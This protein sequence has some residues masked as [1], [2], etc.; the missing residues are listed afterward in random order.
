M[1]ATPNKKVDE[2]VIK[3]VVVK[4]FFT[5]SYRR[6]TPTSNTSS[7]CFSALNPLMTRIPPKVSVNL[8]L[9]SA[10]I[11]PRFRKMGRMI[12]KAFNAIMAKMVNGIKVNKVMNT[13]MS[14][15]KIRETTAVMMPPTSCT[16]PVP[17]RFR[18]PSTSDMIRETSAPDF[19]LSKNRTGRANTFFCTCA[20]S[21]EI[22]Y[23]AC[24]LKIL[25]NKKEVTAC[26]KMANITPATRYFSMSTSLFTIT[27]SMRCLDAIGATKLAAL[28]MAMSKRPRSTNLRLGQIMVLNAVRIL[29]FLLDIAAF[30]KRVQV[31]ANWEGCRILIFLIV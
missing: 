25:V 5:F 18:T 17:M 12:L 10:L 9:T 14:I 16:K 1:V 6:S 20:R 22:R 8:P 4:L 29:T 2:L 27:S 24:T 30:R 21:S 19:A 26:T 7:S 23:C 31:T 15:S 13:L 11:F 28:L 3:A